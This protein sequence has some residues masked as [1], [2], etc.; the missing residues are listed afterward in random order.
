MI[1]IIPNWHPIFV[2]FTVALLLVA[3]MFHVLSQVT[4]NADRAGQFAIVAKWLLW[5]GAGFTV[6]TVAA[7]FYAYNTVD[8]DTPSHLTM[9]TH[10][11]WALITASVFIA[12]ALWSVTLFRENRT[13][14]PVF[15]GVLIIGAGLLAVTAWYGGELVYR[16]GLGV[17]ALPKAEGEGPG[18]DHGDGHSH[19]HSASPAPA[20]HDDISGNTHD[21]THD[22]PEDGAEHSDHEHAPGAAPHEH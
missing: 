21:H 14:N 2:H 17:M 4:R 3:V 7:G 11:N 8:H 15:T 12:A 9:T 13:R 5:V 22:G 6:A 16:H 19:E 10:R 1:E 18:H 20:E